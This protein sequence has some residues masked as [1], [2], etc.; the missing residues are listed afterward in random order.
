MDRSAPRVRREEHE[1]AG[2]TRA[3][4][5]LEIV[6]PPAILVWHSRPG[7]GS[8]VYLEKSSETKEFSRRLQVFRVGQFDKNA[9]DRF[10]SKAG[11]SIY[12]FGNGHPRSE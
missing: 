8:F 2:A 4:I 5:G 10:F 6:A 1:G 3:W 7:C 9:A 11:I 12:D